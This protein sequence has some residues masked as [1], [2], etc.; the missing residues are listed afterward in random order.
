[1]NKLHSRRGSVMIFSLIFAVIICSFCGAYLTTVTNELRLAHRS[2]NYGRAMALAEAGV[3]L[4]L[5]RLNSGLADDSGGWSFSA[6]GNSLMRVYTSADLASLADMGSGREGKIYLRI[7]ELTT[8]KP[9]I[10][11]MGK[12]AGQNGEITKQIKV[13]LTKNT[14]T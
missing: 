1:M 11:S 3:E 10:I 6:D 7:D 13:T 5:W 9:S 12:V 8:D 2:Y 4:A 14:T